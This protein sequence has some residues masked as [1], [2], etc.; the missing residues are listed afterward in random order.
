MRD[1]GLL[2]ICFVPF[3][4]EPDIVW[5]IARFSTFSFIFEHEIP[6]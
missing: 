6:A 4:G 3:W 1:I 5:L 2:D